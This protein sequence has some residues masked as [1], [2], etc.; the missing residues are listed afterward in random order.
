MALQGY[1]LHRYDRIGRMG[2]VVAFYFSTELHPN[3]IYR[4]EGH[5]CV[6]PEY[7]ISEIFIRRF[8]KLLLSVIYRPPHCGYLSEF[9]KKYA[10]VFTQYKHCLIFGE[11]N[12]D[13]NVSSFDSEQIFPFVKNSSL[14]LISFKPTHHTA[15]SSTLLDLCI[16][17][18]QDKLLSF[19][20]KD[21]SFLSAHE[22]ITISYIKIMR[23]CKRTINVRDFRTFN[24]DYFLYDLY[25]SNLDA[26][27]EADNIDT[28]LKYSTI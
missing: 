9:L 19:G 10:D 22:F 5:Y 28:R 15:T 26:L 2:G 13:L 25:G 4:S 1:Q 24:T 21:I 3:I 18:D 6:K 17:Y 8:S 16:I 14:F 11:F 20:Q 12:A 27:F 23:Q 7:L